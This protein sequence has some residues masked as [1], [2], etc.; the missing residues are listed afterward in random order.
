[1]MAARWSFESLAVEQFKNNRFERNFF[2]SNM[3]RS[4]ND[5]YASFLIPEL[6]EELWECRN[7]KDSIRYRERLEGNFY[8]LN[9]YI[10]K[11]YP[12]AGLNFIPGN[13]KDSLTVEKFNSDVSKKAEKYLESLADRFRYFRKENDTRLDS[14]STAI[15]S[16]IGK[17]EFILL[18]KSYNNTS[19]VD[20]VL[21]RTSITD[22]TLET[23][24]K[25]IQRFE[26]AYMK[27]T[28]K[29]GLAQFYAPYK[30]I[31][32]ISFDTYWFNLMVLWSVT[33]ILYITLYFNILQK[34]VT[35][36]SFIRGKIIKKQKPADQI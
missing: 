29:Y 34:A 28:S 14:I 9:S 1:M 24:K 11:L 19:L 17:D 5:W 26:P 10:E 27:P 21:G 22:K 16:R 32:T 20:L 2:K 8:K 7:F 31:G 35:V 36:S 3:E 12:L 23:N 33:F 30:Q 25:I 13:W 4:Q 15:V 18:K 6:K